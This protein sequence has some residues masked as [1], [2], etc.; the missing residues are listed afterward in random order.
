MN[1][2]FALVFTILL[3]FCVAHAQADEP[4]LVI[5]T[6][7]HMAL[8]RK[9]MFTSDGRYL[10]SAGEDKVVRVWDVQTGETVRTI[11]G[12]TAEGDEGKIYAAALSPNDRYLAV[13]GWLAGDPD[14]RC[15]VRIH[16][17]QSGKVIGLLKGHTNVVLSLAFSPDGRY[18]ASGS[19][20]QTV[21][22]WDIERKEV[23]V[24]KGHT[25]DIYA[26]AFSS[27]GKRLVSGSDDH[28]LRLWDVQQ[29][30][31]IKEMKGHQD[32]VS[33]A[34]F[35][36]D[37]R[38][39]ASG[40]WDKT[41]RLWDAES[42]DFVKV[43][44]EQ[45]TTVDSLSFS[46]DS[47]W[48]LTGSGFGGK[49]VCNVFSVPA[50]QIMTRFEKHD[51]VVRAT[52]VSPDGTTAATAGGYNKEIYLWNPHS[53]Q[54]FKHLAG[55]GRP[56][57]S[58]G[59][60]RDGRSLAFENEFNKKN[61]NNGGP[62]QKIII[63]NQDND[64]QVTLGGKTGKEADYLRAV[65][66]SGDSE[67]TTIKVGAYN[68]EAILQV[69][70]AGKVLHEIERDSTSGYAHRS[71][72]FT[73]DGRYIVSGG[74][75]GV[76]TLYSTETGK[77]VRPF[78]G[79]SHTADVRA[80][81]VSPDNRIAVSGSDN[82]TVRLWDIASG[83][84]LLTIFVGS[85]HE[86]VAWTPQ[87]YYTS[88]L[89]GDQYIGWHLNQ[90]VDQA[91]N[92]YSAARFQKQFYRPDVVAEYLKTR[93]IQLAVKR[94]NEERSGTYRGQPVVTPAALQAFLPPLVY[95][96]APEQPES[97]VQRDTLSVK[98]VALSQTLP[99]TEV[100]V[101]LNGILR[102][103]VKGEPMQQ[104]VE[105]E[106]MLEPGTNTLTFIAANEKANS[107][108]IFRRIIY[109]GQKKDER[110]DLILL[111]IGISAYKDPGLGLDF[112]DQDAMDVEK[113]FK[114]Q[115]GRI[116]NKVKPKQL[117]N[118]QAT[119]TNILRALNWLRKEGTPKD[120]RLLFLSGHG[121]LDRQNNYYFFA[122]DHDPQEDLAVSNV[123]WTEILDR[124]TEVPGK[125]ILMVDTCR[126]AAIASGGK[127]RSTVNFEEILKEMQSDYRG[128]VT[129]AASTGRQVSVERREWGHGAFTQALLEGLAG[130]ADGYGGKAD[131]YIE[132]KELG[133]WII[134]RVWE[135]TNKE[136][137]AIHSQPP[138]LPSFPLFMLK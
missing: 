131:S 116:F 113:A 5:D 135:L 84:N 134:D 15:A 18:L 52:A 7:G 122:Y 106:V 47:H 65:E 16:D 120:Y 123:K 41:V 94:A 112:A 71:Y 58:V 42:G 49:D 68:Y 32:R 36:P 44:G 34:A 29:G 97:T 8:I 19:A 9:I 117:T 67:L 110:P 43:L 133:S 98:A 69:T 37:G 31:L 39:I 82:Q 88:S 87:E 105:V 51:N 55:K 17:F 89:N 129:F 28:T 104:P 77:E 99:I 54:I 40:S 13:G 79:H 59:F 30:K 76:L 130:K 23:H 3:C 33:S 14:S 26:V 100:K 66:K 111:T 103:R 20:D 108:P 53:G 21:R 61:D 48:L 4:L 109:A 50:G 80:V 22:M 90:G 2:S 10:V 64:Y 35:S 63:L 57:S 136:Q 118:Q 114:A 1:K 46:P 70:K 132:T 124:L 128:L 102:A 96:M 38:Y 72:T 24:L 60:A 25:G 83:Q 74:S 126:A 138:E 27:D 93:D 73:H 95:V 121:G 56:I 107:E 45:G 101:F 81:A 11:R 86:W 12:Q 78:V 119:R 125:A 75:N 62:L 85:D 127:T 115:E 92:Y 6:G 91:A 137:K